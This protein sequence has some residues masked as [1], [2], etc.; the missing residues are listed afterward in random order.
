MENRNSKKGMLLAIVVAIIAGLLGGLLGGFLF[1]RTGPQGEQ[2]AQGLKGD[3]GDQG[4]QGIQ[5][6]PGMNG[7]NSVV[8]I[9]QSQNVTSA[10]L[11]GYNLSE[12]YDM[13]VF[14]SSMRF[15]VSVQDQSRIYAEFLSSVSIPSQGTISLMIVVDGQI[16]STV[17]NVGITNVPALTITF[18]VHAKILTNALTAGQHTIDVQFMRS[19][20]APTLMQRSL[21]ISELASP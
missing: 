9:V 17:Y 1:A 4:V 13:F 21:Y 5:G 18:P 6:L 2:G 8:Q 16:N 12:W 3:Q 15:T 14:D 7:S 19:N 10:N 20:G 11:G